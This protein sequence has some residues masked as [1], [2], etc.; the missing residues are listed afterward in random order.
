MNESANYSGS[1][2]LSTSFL[3][4]LELYLEM[5]FQYKSEFETGAWDEEGAL[6]SLSVVTFPNLTSYCSHSSG[7]P[8]QVAPSAEDKASVT[9]P[10]CVSVSTFPAFIS[11]SHLDWGP[12]S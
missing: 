8:Y 10:L 12:P 3:M 2:T 1:L 7:L 9:F 4:N 11:T 6:V 5:T